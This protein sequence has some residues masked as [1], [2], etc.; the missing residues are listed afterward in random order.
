MPP[1]QKAGQQA[2]DLQAS[3]GEAAAQAPGTSGQAGPASFRGVA[4]SASASGLEAVTA[5]LDALHPDT[6]MVFSLV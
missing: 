2:T 4:I 5:L 1:E 6:N 3:P